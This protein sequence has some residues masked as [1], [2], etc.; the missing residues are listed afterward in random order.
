MC[1]L[2][3]ITSDYPYSECTDP[4]HIYKK[5]KSLNYEFGLR[6]KVISKG[7]N[8]IVRNFS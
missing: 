6:L 3:I 8:L 5:V 7:G 4:A 2:E 1:V